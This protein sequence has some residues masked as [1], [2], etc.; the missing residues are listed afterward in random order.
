MDRMMKS[1]VGGMSIEKKQEMMLK[2]MPMMMEDVNMAETM[3]KMVPLMADQISLLDVFNVLKKL[4]PRILS[5]V[6]SLA[7]LIDRWDEIFPK[8]VRKMP[9]LME[10]MMPMMELMMPKIMARVMPLMLTGQNM[11]RMED[12]AERVAPKMMEN[13]KL[14]EIMPELMAR[15]MPHWLGN[16]LPHLSEEKRAVFVASMK[17]ILETTDLGR[18]GWLSPP[19]CAARLSEILDCGR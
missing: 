9:E 11:Q 13:E 14:R 19:P 17:S 16:M 4:F 7:E 6:S 1:M 18:R 8:L 2:M 5:G 10:K 12:C 3:V 15:I